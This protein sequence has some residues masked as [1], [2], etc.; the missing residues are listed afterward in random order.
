M[1]SLLL[2][3]MAKNI[4]TDNQEKVQ[5]YV[6]G[7]LNDYIDKKEE[8]KQRQDEELKVLDEEEQE[9]TNALLGVY[10][11]IAFADGVIADEEMKVISEVF[12]YIDL[13]LL[14]QKIRQFIKKPF[15]LD[16][17]P[18]IFFQKEARIMIWK[19]AYIIANSD[20]DFAEEEQE[21]I[22]QLANI[23]KFSESELE[24]YKADAHNL[25]AEQKEEE[26][27]LIA[28]KQEIESHA[29]KVVPLYE[30]ALQTDDHE[31]ARKIF[32]DAFQK[33]YA[34]DPLEEVNR[35]FSQHITDANILNIYPDLKEEDL[36]VV[37][38]S[39]GSN[40][41]PGE[42]LVTYRNGMFSAKKGF[43]VTYRGIASSNIN[44]S[45][46]KKHNFIAFHD[47]ES[48]SR[49][50]D[51]LYIKTHDGLNLT[52]NHL[53]SSSQIESLYHFISGVIDG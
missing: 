23:F 50:G 38:S 2:G 28:R 52:L 19:T 35:H 22:A 10:S 45:Q 47:M 33:L 24:D 41:H 14:N 48:F 37:L 42:I 4:V 43:T 31:K 6:S 1:L 32:S 3:S 15:D 39:Y 25:L 21:I 51:S 30:K 44:D 5:N 8:E 11:K 12:D 17:L 36:N 27:R 20:N 7:R 13:Q 16:E 53:A 46:N 49:A 40:L 34:K 26:D 9:R 18:M 29:Q